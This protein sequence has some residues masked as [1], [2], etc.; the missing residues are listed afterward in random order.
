MQPLQSSRGVNTFY[1][2]IKLFLML[3][4]LKFWITC[5]FASWLIESTRMGTNYLGEGSYLEVIPKVM[6][7]IFKR[8]EVM[9]DSTEFFIRVAFIEVKDSSS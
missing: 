7:S 2:K 9:K 1:P 6:E 8:V 5:C 4:Q 3:S